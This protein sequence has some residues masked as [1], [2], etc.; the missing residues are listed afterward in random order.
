MEKW[1]VEQLLVLV[2]GLFFS[3]NCSSECTFRA[4]VYFQVSFFFNTSQFLVENL[5]LFRE[6]LVSSLSLLF[7]QPI[8]CYIG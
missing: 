2:S 4:C 8:I 7:R 1:N 6:A 3:L 5:K